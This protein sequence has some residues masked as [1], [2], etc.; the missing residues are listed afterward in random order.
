MKLLL[1]L[2]T[3][4]AVCHVWLTFERSVRCSST[5]PNGVSR[6]WG[7]RKILSLRQR[8]N[9]EA[10]EKRGAK[11]N[12]GGNPRKIRCCKQRRNEEAFERRYAKERN[13]G[14]AAPPT[15]PRGGL[16]PPSTP[17][18]ILSGVRMQIFLLQAFRIAI[19]IRNT[20]ATSEQGGSLPPNS[21][22]V[23]IPQVPPNSAGVGIPQ[24][25][26]QRRQLVVFA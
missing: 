22:G 16:R 2:E 19:W 4:K 9:E 5:D 21:A 14:G 7:P 15:P 20:G 10:F 8:R 1:V 13:G 26:C 6:I 17:R 11:K 23:G 24:V 18:F 12:N 25:A 3:M